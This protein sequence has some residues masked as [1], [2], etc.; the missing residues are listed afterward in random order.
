MMRCVRN[1]RFGV[2]FELFGR[3]VVSGAGAPLL[4]QALAARALLRRAPLGESRFT[5]RQLGGVPP[6]FPIAAESNRSHE[7]RSL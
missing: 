1:G 2:V 7:R 4:V 3:P 5:P 6:I